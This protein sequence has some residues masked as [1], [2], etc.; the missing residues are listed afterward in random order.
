MSFKQDIN[1]Y[2][3]LC[4]TPNKPVLVFGQLEME[5]PIEIINSTV[6]IAGWKGL[7]SAALS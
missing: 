4:L 2:K 7:P 1:Y 3:I 6:I 5:S